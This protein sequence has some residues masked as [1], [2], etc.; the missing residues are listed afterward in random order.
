MP[1]GERADRLVTFELEQE[2]AAR[3]PEGTVPV[4]RKDLDRIDFRQSLGQLIGKYPDVNRKY[5]LGG[6]LQ[7][8]PPS[9]DGPHRY[10]STSQQIIAFGGEGVLSAFD[11]YGENA[12]DFSL[13]QIACTN[14]DL[15]R[16]QTVEACWQQRKDS[17]GD[18]VPH[19]YTYYTT[20]G[21]ISDGDGKGGH[22]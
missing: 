5:L 4:L 14:S 10:A 7:A 6:R 11:P 12:D 8:P 20:N 19:L 18:W 3:G 1:E 2:G 15:G 13:M 16:M 17:Y 21:H 9:T 22:N